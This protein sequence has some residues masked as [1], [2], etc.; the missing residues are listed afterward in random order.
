[1]II[2][3]MFLL[4]AGIITSI[5]GAK[6]FKLLLPLL[7]FIIGFMVG[8]SGF[9]GIFGS[10]AVSTTMAIVIALC[11]GILL[12]LLSF[13]FF[14]IAV[15]VFTIAVGAMAMGY[16]GVAL[17][18]SED[19]LVVFL[20]SLA[21]AILA[22]IF[23]V[24]VGIS[25]RLVIALTSLL[26]VGFVLVALMLLVG[27]VSVDEL[28][29]DGVTMTIL[30]IVDQSF[31]WFFVWIGG[32]LISMRLQYRLMVASLMTTMFELDPELNTKRVK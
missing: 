10:G 16:L 30:N 22:G 19:G 5:M 28:S 3:A 11:I 23:A 17:G 13:L 29:E 4:I 14:E 25:N 27:K 6:L 18:L 1:M 15:I 12:A 21:G 20:L 2:T 7:G 8:F 26:G 32:S 9:Q 31:L 24:N